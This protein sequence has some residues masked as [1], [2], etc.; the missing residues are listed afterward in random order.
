M[1]YSYYLATALTTTVALLF[2]IPIIAGLTNVVLSAFGYLPALGD[3]SPTFQAWRQLIQTPALIEMLALSIWVG[4]ISTLLSLILALGFVTSTWGKKPW[5]KITPWLSPILATPHV[6]LA[7]GFAFLIMPSGIISRLIAPFTDWDSP[8][9][10]QTTQDHM[11]LSMI[12]FLVLKETPF[13]IFMLI[14]ATERLSVRNTLDL[15]Q[16]LGY[17]PFISWVKLVWP[18][19]YVMIRMPV[20]AVLA[21][22]MSVVDIA[23][24]LGP[25]TPPIFSVQILQWLQDPD[26]SSQLSAAA[27]SVLLAMLIFFALMIFI[28]AERCICFIARPWL[29]AG[30]RGKGCHLF[31]LLFTNGWR[32][33]LT[34]FSCSIASL[35]I[36][37]FTWRWRF[38]S[39]WPESFTGNSWKKAATY[40]SE[41]L[42]NSLLIGLSSSLIS[43][44]AAVLL[45][46]FS[47]KIAANFEK[48]VQIMIY[49]PMLLPQISFLF[50]IQLGLIKLNIN[51]FYLSVIAVHIL[52]VLPYCYLSLVGPW[53]S[54]DE[55]HMTQA[56]LLSHSRLKSFT[57]IK[58]PILWRPLA[59][60]FALGFAV[61]IAQYLPTLFIG[62][63]RVSTITTEAVS[64]AS[65]GNR[66]LIAVYALIQMLLPLL[67]YGLALLSASWSL[68]K[69][70]RRLI[71]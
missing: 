41:P 60:S 37:S 21:Y 26:L 23:I 27:A 62:A 65:G 7:F 18:H 19:L 44:L 25:D 43:M 28:L 48:L 32:C 29:T 20:Y 71:T 42:T 53:R 4:L 67:I 14:A 51:H 30:G 50:G 3:T 54:F 15:A 47:S 34:T 36:W 49:I 35:V 56:L 24:I 31:D 40:V 63:G 57:H 59:A 5:R 13:L 22:S 33:L 8:P 1:K 39:L 6:A 17:Q 2:F 9:D 46:E 55:R 45:L 64:L 38:P 10:W 11:G 16:S 70:R 12:F 58:L 61:S 52:F 69:F 66:R 68:I